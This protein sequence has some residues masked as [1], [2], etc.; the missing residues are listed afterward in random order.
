MAIS[1]WNIIQIQLRSEELWSGQGFSINVHCDIDLG[2]MTMTQGND[3]PLG[4]GQQVCEILSRSNLAAR[5]YSPD[6]D[7]G[8]CTVTLNLE[9]CP[10]VKVMTHPW[11]MDDN[12]VKYYQ[13]QTWQWGVYSPDT[14][15]TDEQTDRRTWWFLYPPNFV[16]GGIKSLY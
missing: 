1:A 6:T 12:C 9:I 5:S 14:M 10:S 2:Y 8:M 7:L 11:V 3:T 13:E 16:R 4:Y 15:W